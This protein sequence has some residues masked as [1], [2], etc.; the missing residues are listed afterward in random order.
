MYLIKYLIDKKPQQNYINQ[1]SNSFTGLEEKNVQ[2]KHFS[3]LSFGLIH[4]LDRCRQPVG[5]PLAGLSPFYPADPGNP[6]NR[7]CLWLAAGNR[8][9]RPLPTLRGRRSP[10][11]QRRQ[12]RHR[13]PFRA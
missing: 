11:L 12:W 6:P 10:R 4:G 1:V 13:R 9:R 5:G 7:G 3:A 8:R 2:K